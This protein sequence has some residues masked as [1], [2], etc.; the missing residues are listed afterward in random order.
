MDGFLPARRLKFKN[1]AA[2]EQSVINIEIGVFCGGSDEGNFSVFHKFQQRL[3]LL[4]VEILDFVQIEQSALRGEKGVQLFYNGLDIAERSGSGVE[5]IELSVGLGGNDARQGGFA[6]AGRAV[7]NHIGNLTAFDD[8]AQNTV[9]A[10]QVALAHHIVQRQ[11][12]DLICQRL[13]HNVTWPPRG[14]K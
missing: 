11:R 7:K 1:R 14:G 2:A 10:D 3:L 5:A 9:F 6:H 12:A 8:S 13:I 4:F